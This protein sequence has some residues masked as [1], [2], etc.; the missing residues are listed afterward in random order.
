MHADLLEEEP[1]AQLVQVDARPL[2]DAK[3]D[4]LDTA[5]LRR[6]G[7]ERRAREVLL[8]DR[9]REHVPEREHDVLRDRVQQRKRVEVHLVRCAASA[10]PADGSE[11][12]TDQT[13]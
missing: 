13:G 2:H 1:I 9:D 5:R 12:S 10:G 3:V 8:V 4:R 6:R 11:G 7:A